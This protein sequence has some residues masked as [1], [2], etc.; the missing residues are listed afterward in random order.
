MRRKCGRG[1]G[2]GCERE[3]VNMNEGFEW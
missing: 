1:K 2:V 3:Y